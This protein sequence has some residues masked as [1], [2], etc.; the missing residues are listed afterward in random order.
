[1]SGTMTAP[2][3]DVLAAPYDEGAHQAGRSHRLVV[4]FTFDVSLHTW[5]E[6][7]LLQREIHIYRSL[8][9]QGWTVTFLTYGDERDLAIAPAI[10]PI[11]VC[12]LHARGWRP[13]SAVLRLL[14]SP[15][16]LWRC[17]RELRR[18]SV[19][20][21]NQTWG[22]WNAALASTVFGV[23]LLARSGYELYAF[24]LREGRSLMRRL[25]VRWVSMLTYRTAAAIMVATEADRRF[26]TE[27]FGLA[28]DR[29]LVQP[30]W[31]DTSL[32]R[33]RRPDVATDL[34]AVGR[35]TRQKN[36]ETLIRAA[37]ATGRRLTLIGTGE[38]ASA[39][40]AVARERHAD[41]VFIPKVDNETLPERLA[42]AR[43]FVVTS[44]YEGNPKALLEAMACGCAVVAA[45]VPGVHDVVRHGETGWLYDGSVAGLIDAIERLMGDEPLCRRLGAAARRQIEATNSFEVQLAREARILERLAQSGTMRAGCASR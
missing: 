31:I 4:F 43:M 2:S 42:A 7:G 21:T 15:I 23:P 12:A 32:F 5:F 22:G 25:F 26:V 10:A 30:N 29:I 1:M 34:I 28:P 13:R 19:V 3:E 11:R 40:A 37:A 33:P 17:R 44:L 24:T 20:K 16:M 6:K 35:L 38:E 39:L 27:R 14:M 8:A 41:V 45:D 36:F 9:A 18:A